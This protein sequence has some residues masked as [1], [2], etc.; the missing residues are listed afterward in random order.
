MEDW[1]GSATQRAFATPELLEQIL[2]Y[3]LFFLLPVTDQE[4]PRSVR[5]LSNASVLRHLL[6]CTLVSRDWHACILGSSRIRRALYW[7][8]D[9]N[10]TRSWDMAASA[11]RARRLYSYYTAPHFRAPQLN[12]VIQTTIP[13]YHLRFWHLSLESTG[14]KHCAYLIITRQDVYPDIRRREQTGNGRS[15]SKMLLS[16]PPCTSLEA[17]IW[18]ER[19]L[20]K[21]W[22]G[23]TSR[24]NDPLIQC[25]E[26]VTVGLVH[27]R[28]WEMFDEHRDVTAI[29]LVTNQ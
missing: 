21:D 22:V 14:N 17:T 2:I 13:A 11:T 26:G 18:E 23:R 28:V 6:Q 8:S 27:R 7:E 5:V 20:P 1:T 12:P 10:T 24:L 16:Q 3:L 4:D 29:K 15:I 19:D 25:D 9:P